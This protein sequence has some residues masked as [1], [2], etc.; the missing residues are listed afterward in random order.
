MRPLA[1]M[2][3]LLGGPLLAAPVPKA[4]KVKADDE[5]ILGVWMVAAVDGLDAR[6]LSADEVAQ[7]R[8]Y[9]LEDGLFVFDT[10][11]SWSHGGKF[12]LDAK[13]VTK[14]LNFTRGDWTFGGLYELDGDTLTLCWNLKDGQA[15]QELKADGQ[16]VVVWTLKRVAD[17]QK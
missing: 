7:S 17:E 11:T 14:R 3:A 10:P 6:L 4:I 15:P 2:T 13:A 5:A 1:V 12:K 16:G 8:F 9:F